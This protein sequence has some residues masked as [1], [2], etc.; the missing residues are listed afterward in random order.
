MHRRRSPRGSK[1][2][3]ART[4]GT[5]W[6]AVVALLLGLFLAAAAVPTPL[7]TAYGRAWH[8][9]TFSLTAVFAVY[10]V[11]LLGTLLAFGPVSDT[12]GRRPLL[13]AGILLEL[14]SLVLFGLADA[15]VWL[16][17]ARLVQGLATGLVFG[18]LG[19]A[20]LDFEPPQRDGTAAVAN[21]AAPM[22]GSAVGAFA[23]AALVQWAPEPL[24]LVYWGALV[25]FALL[26]L[27]VVAMPESVPDA[28]PRAWRSAVSIRLALPRELRSLFVALTPIFV[29]VWALGGLFFSLGPAIGQS[30][31]RSQN[32]LVT[33]LV[34][35]VLGLTGAA[36]AVSTRHWSRQRTLLGGSACMVVGCALLLAALLLDL[37]WLLLTATAVTGIGWG[38]GFLGAF[39]AITERTPD[40]TRAGVI[41]TILLLSYGAFSI[42]ALAAG[43]AVPRYG[44]RT[45]ASFYDAVLIVLAATTLAL[46]LHRRSE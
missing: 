23:S 11:T 21:G 33:V 35:A 36:S 24:H 46:V 1:Q 29:S 39:G 43:L 13:I 38:S 16:V 44:L 28:T 2:S 7:Y 17:A 18:P 32:H 3:E 40:E 14:A 22:S 30:V 9:S 45:T 25:P 8:L 6:F 26:L 20:L 4:F 27:V 5:I 10:A 41:S 31:L 19:A 15:V 37:G 34:P 42:P 12:A